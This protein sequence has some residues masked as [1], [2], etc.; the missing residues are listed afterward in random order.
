MVRRVVLITIGIVLLVIGAVTAIAGGG[1]IAFFGS[2]DTV[3][4]GTINVST[5]DRA[6]VLPT[7]S[8]H[9][10]S[11]EQ[12]AF[13]RVRLVITTT[14]AGAGE[15]L[16]LGIAST[17]AVDLYLRGVSR[18][19]GT[20]VSISPFHVTLAPHRGT[21]T[22]T[23]P[24]S[25]SFWLAKASGIN[26]TLA[27]TITSGHYRMVAMNTNAS[28]PVALVAGLALSIPHLFAIGFGLLVG[29]IVLIVI[30]IIL[31][32]LSART[33]PQSQLVPDL[34]VEVEG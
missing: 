19:V 8:I 14:Q 32:R 34:P 2:S 27:W 20:S 10:T 30:A 23:P 3:T 21:V 15:H 24:G 22:P 1:E 6:V 9:H 26:P 12:T 11:L 13:G 28:A 18:D 29:G 16:F 33:Q 25:Q 4:F 17:T 7:G 5:P 31:I